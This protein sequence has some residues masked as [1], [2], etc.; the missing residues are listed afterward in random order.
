MWEAWKKSHLAAR[1]GILLVSLVCAPSN[2][3]HLMTFLSPAQD[4]YQLKSPPRIYSLIN[5]PSPAGVVLSPS[6]LPCFCTS[7][8]SPSLLVHLEL[9]IVRGKKKIRVLVK[10]HK[11]QLISVFISKEFFLEAWPTNV[12][13]S[14]IV[15][16]LKIDFLSQTL[17][18][19]N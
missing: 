17:Q 16:W 1:R 10:K 15:S 6:N 3:A 8:S 12:C 14:Q 11:S 4:M 13:K 18:M 7:I 2:A 9:K 19:S 5:P